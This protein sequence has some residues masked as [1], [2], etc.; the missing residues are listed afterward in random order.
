MRGKILNA[1]ILAEHSEATEKAKQLF[2]KLKENQTIP[3]SLKQLVYSV[4]VKTGE[5]EDWDWCYEK[6]RT[7]N[8]PSDRAI[9][10]H[11]LGETSNIFILQK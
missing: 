2:Q 8:V 7:T 3:A 9:L 1:A 10:L 11:A 5:E 4:G 6:Y